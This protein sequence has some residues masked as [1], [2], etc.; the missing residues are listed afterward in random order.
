M[1]ILVVSHPPLSA[2][3][4]AAQIAVNLADALRRRGHDASA[5]SPEPLPAATKWWNLWRQQR[6]A[7]ERHAAATG[8]YDVIDTPAISATAALARHGNVVVRSVQPELRYLRRAVA[9][10]LRR[11]PSPRA[12]AHALLSLGRA[13][14]IRTGWDVAKLVLCLGELEL[15]WMRR[16]FPRWRAKLG[17]YVSAVP[18]SER[19]ELLR[20]RALRERNEKNGGGTRFLWL[21]RWTGHK[22]TARL[23]AILTDR[24]ARFPA[25]SATIGG[26]GPL[27]RR[28]L[29]ADWL[30]AGRV[31]VVESYRRKELGALLAE[32]DVGLF[33]SS[34]EGWGLSLA[35]MLESGMPV[36]ASEAGAVPDL[37]PF[38]PTSLRSLP[39]P[40]RLPAA[41]LED[42]AAN[43][44]LGRFD[45]DI[46]ASDY[47]AQV[48]AAC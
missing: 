16:S 13:R 45:W 46:I 27:A 19:H 39:V 25:D 30:A 15:E 44:Y 31:R 26:C 21:G 29:P 35:E 2:E 36:Y 6:D 4:G 20:L 17:S 33:T 8:P 22:G 3:L 42:L 34:V 38:F 5:W 40:G 43:G 11:R 48:I 1:R 12:I 37:R 9:G 23:L 10:D 28:E 41:Q 18:A 47:E 7:L 14:A 24:F 32:H